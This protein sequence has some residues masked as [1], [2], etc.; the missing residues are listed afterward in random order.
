MTALFALLCAIIGTYWYVTDKV[1]VR[2]MAEQYLTDLIGGPVTVRDA[3]LSIFEG[4]RLDDVRVFAD[5]SGRPE[6]RLFTASSFT[7][8]YNPAALFSGRIEAT[9]IIAIEPRMYFTEDLDTG[10]W[11]YERLARQRR[12]TTRGSRMPS[13]GVLPQVVLRSAQVEYSRV[14]QGRRSDRGTI[15]IEGQFTP[16]GG[17]KYAFQ[18]QSL[19][20]R[21]GV[22]PVV[23]GNMHLLTGQVTAELLNFE[24]GEDVKAMLPKPV[25]R[26]CEQHGLAGGMDVEELTFSQRPTDGPADD[27]SFSAR[28]R[29]RGVKLTVSPEEWMGARE[30]ERLNALRESIAVMRVGGLN[31]RGFVDRFS[32]LVEPAP[33]QLKEVDSVFV[34]T[35]DGI[36]ID[37]LTG[38]LEDISFKIDGRIDG[39]DPSATAD[40]T[41]ASLESRLVEIPATPRYVTS[42]PRPV[43]EVYDRFKPRGTASFWLNLKRPEPDARPQITGE[44]DILDG[45]FVFENFPYPLRGATGKIVLAHDAG[46]GED[47]LRLVRIRGR[48]L[49]GGVNEHAEVEI[50]GEMGPFTPDIGVNVIVSGTN[51]QSE[52][53][54]T[55]AF[56]EQTREALT[57]FD[58]PGKGEY[59]RFRGDFVCRIVRLKQRHSKWVIETDIRLADASGVLVAFPYP[60][61]GVTGDLKIRDDHL[62]IVNASMTRGDATMRI[63]GRVD[64]QKSPER[65]RH[66]PQQSAQR[67]A[68]PSTRPSTQ[69]APALR[70][71]LRIVAR[72]V[73]IDRDLLAALPEDRRAW[74]EKIGARGRFDL[75]GTV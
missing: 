32:E 45:S 68:R 33:I 5:R 72:N 69:P 19:G 24:F 39:Y 61:S 64:W 1:R 18:F 8:E 11:N 40:L 47:S 62:E 67:A 43:R 42:M 30:I 49:A 54:L 20:T 44:I 3:T 28:I 56:P 58:A 74:L 29:V 13:I 52:P 34:F 57:V 60:M 71:D 48:G 41:I 75:D 70:P 15:T 63:D 26:W 16:V 35:E 36:T 2:Q 22:G 17:D 12:S 65:E 27:P 4:L 50:N 14:E 10:R 9:R 53:L 7:I 66:P 55:A 25:H 73:P 37:G 6:S 23:R 38:K 51:V 59:P 21:Q 46:S 31:A